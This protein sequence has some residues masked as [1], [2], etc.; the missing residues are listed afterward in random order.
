MFGVAG[1][2][3]V[4]GAEAAMVADSSIRLGGLYSISNVVIESDVAVPFTF[5]SVA[6]PPLP[7]ERGGSL[8]VADMV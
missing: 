5:G 2:T 3:A 1:C 6:E 8:W 4:F 7:I